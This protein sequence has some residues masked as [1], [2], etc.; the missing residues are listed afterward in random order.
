MRI[1]SLEYEKWLRDPR[2]SE[3]VDNCELSTLYQWLWETM[4]D[5]RL[6]DRR[7]TERAE[8]VSPTARDGQTPSE[9]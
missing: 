8:Q 3:A 7:S 5:G 1:Y 2:I 4:N 9:D 6:H